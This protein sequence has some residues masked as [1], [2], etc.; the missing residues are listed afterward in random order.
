MRLVPP[1]NTILSSSNGQKYTSLIAHRE[2]LNSRLG[3]GTTWE[4]SINLLL[5]HPAPNTGHSFCQLMMS[6]PLQVFPGTPLF[7]TI[8][9][10]WRSENGVTFTFLPENGSDA[11]NII[12]GLIPYLHYTGDPWYMSMFT[13]EAKYRHASSKWDQASRQVFSIE[14]FEIDEFLADDDEYNKTD[15]PTAE[16]P[17]RTTV[18][19]ESHIQINVPIIIDPE[20]SP[21]MYKDDDSFSTFH[22]QEPSSPTLVSPS[23]SF[24]PKIVSNPPSILA[25]SNSDSK[26]SDINYHDDAESVSKLLDM[27]SRISSIEQDIKH[28][29]A[30]FQHALEEMKLQSQQQASQKTFYDSTLA[31]ILSLL[32]Q[33]KVIDNSANV[34]H[35]S[36]ARDNQPEQLYPSGGSDRAAGSG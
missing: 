5:D 36:S 20:E 22:Q 23:K 21:K 4:M 3:T 2:A 27:Q 11:R 15:E 28:L 26:P 31:E 9:K 33:S 32:K 18:M 7:H 24:T 6:I 10:Q 13:I 29:H 34:I 30:T 14:E 25:P 17:N 16:R 12:A 19:D 35:H 1:F 8:G